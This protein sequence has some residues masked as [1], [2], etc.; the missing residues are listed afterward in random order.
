[1]RKEYNVKDLNPRKNPYARE[2][3][4]Q[5]TIKLKPSTIAFFKNKSGETGIP[6]QTLINLYL[7]D[8][9]ARKKELDIN[10]R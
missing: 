5:V 9:A 1:M 7:D 8:C 3:K 4:K 2:L 6:Y 10:W